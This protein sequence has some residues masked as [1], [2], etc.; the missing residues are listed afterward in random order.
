MEEGTIVQ[1]RKS[2]MPEV[3]LLQK[4]DIF[5]DKYNVVLIVLKNTNKSEANYFR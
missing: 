4:I 5:I 1:N 3:Y 2:M